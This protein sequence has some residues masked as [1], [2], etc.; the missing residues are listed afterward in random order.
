M[1]RAYQ[2]QAMLLLLMVMAGCAKHDPVPR[3]NVRENTSAKDRY[4]VK[5]EN[6]DGMIPHSATARYRIKNLSCVPIDYTKAIGGLRPVFQHSIEIP[7]RKDETGGAVGTVYADAIVP[8]DYYGLEKCNWELARVAIRAKTLGGLEVSASSGLP[9]EG[10]ARQSEKQICPERASHHLPV[11]GC[12][13]EGANVRHDD[14][15]FHV[16]VQLIKE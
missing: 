5:F 14:Y 16:E 3:P 2:L 7:L 8:E 11:H 4:L 12:L 1:I 6:S 10:V 13:S 9:P 15:P